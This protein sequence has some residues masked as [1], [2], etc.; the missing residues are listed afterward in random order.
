MIENDFLIMTAAQ[1]WPKVV[2][3]TVVVV[4]DV[5]EQKTSRTLVQTS[6]SLDSELR[7]M[8]EQTIQDF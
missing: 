4:A 1:I 3:T 2:I 7:H 5:G 8:D 6:F